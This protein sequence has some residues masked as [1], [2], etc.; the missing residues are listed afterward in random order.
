LLPG[1]GETGA[2]AFGVETF[3]RTKVFGSGTAGLEAGSV[4]QVGD[5]TTLRPYVSGGITAFTDDKWSMEARLIGAPLGTPNFVVT[6]R[7]PGLLGRVTAGVE[8]SF[9]DATV[10]AEFEDRM[11]RGYNDPTG[12]LKVEL[13]L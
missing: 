10:R 13:R 3:D 9:G 12:T 11:G 7:F 1:F 8:A 6:N 4:F 5:S 2:G